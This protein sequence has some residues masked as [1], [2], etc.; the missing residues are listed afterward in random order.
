[1]PPGELL[2][3]GSRTRE[4]HPTQNRQIDTDK[5]ANGDFV[6]KAADQPVPSWNPTWIRDGVTPRVELEN[7]G[8]SANPPVSSHSECVMNMF[9][10]SI[11][12]MNK[13]R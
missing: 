8:I 12:L 3:S 5:L 2:R 4:A 7:R 9:D 1:M 10:C 13:E 6:T 11:E